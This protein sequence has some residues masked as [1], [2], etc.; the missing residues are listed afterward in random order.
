MGKSAD[1]SEGIAVIRE[2]HND[3][4]AILEKWR[5]LI[6]GPGEVALS[7]KG[8]NGAAPHTITVPSIREAISRYLGGTFEK[9]T[10]TYNGLSATLSLDEAGNVVIRNADDSLGALSAHRLTVSSIVPESGGVV[11]YGDTVLSGGTISRATISA[12]ESYGGEFYNAAFKGNTAISGG[13]VITGNATIRNAAIAKLNTG[14]V[15]YR[16]QI[17]KW[18]FE[19]I[20]DEQLNGSTAGGLWTGSVEA[21]ER[22]GI[23]E[24]PTWADCIHVP[25]AFASTAATVKVYY[26]TPD[27]GN[28][29]VEHGGGTDFPPCYA[30]MWPY[31]MYEAVEG[32][33]RIRWLPLDNEAGRITYLRTGNVATGAGQVV[34]GFYPYLRV[35]GAGTPSSVLAPTV[36]TPPSYICRRLMANLDTIAETPAL[37]VDHRLYET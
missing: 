31:K 10:L 33:Y 9:I 25:G 21:L 26:G 34:P 11:F 17:L 35:V 13:A 7:V 1:F 18:G 16:K 5:E 6:E 22:A 37:I 14:T 15:N 3:S 27:M 12:V 32:G 23:T 28:V 24:T 19:A 8:G 29:L 30:A 4:V 36:M 2:A 20:V